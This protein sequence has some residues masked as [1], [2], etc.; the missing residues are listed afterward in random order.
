MSHLSNQLHEDAR[1]RFDDLGLRLLSRVTTFRDNPARPRPDFSPDVFNGETLTD[2]DFAIVGVRRKWK[3]TK[4]GKLTGIAFTDSTS[5]RAAKRS[6]TGE[7]SF[8]GLIGPNYEELEALARLMADARPFH[9]AASVEFLRSQIFEWVQEHHRGHV[10]SGC[11]DYVLRALESAATDHRMIFPVSQLH[12]QSPLT[13][14][15]VTVATFPES[16][17][18]K[19]EPKLIDNPSAAK[20]AEWCRSMREDFQGLAVAETCVFG[21]PIRALEIAS[22]RV[23]LAVGVL[24]FFAPSHLKPWVTSRIA[25]WGYAPSRNSYV[26]I[27]DAAGQLLSTSQ[28]MIDQPGTM[29]VDDATRDILLGIGLSEVRDIVAREADSR[30]DLE[31]ALLKGMVT[32]GRAALASDFSERI[33]WYCAGLESILLRG[34]DQIV[35]SLS[36]RLAL[37]G[38]DTVGE[39]LAAVKDVK[40]AYKLRSNFVHHGVEIGESEIVTRFAR[41]GQRVFSR[42]AQNVASFD[43]KE[44]LLSH[45]DRIKLSGSS[46]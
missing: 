40:K 28:A 35:S 25:R 2:A 16:I 19:I 18:E 3:N 34:S 24:R 26:F 12:V 1:K 5:A 38:Y 30:N 15:S 46:Q 10:S 32:F 37:F 43:S 7:D 9:L 42:I 6:S 27:V 8:V 44:E 20:R 29:V 4:T 21:E 11:V 17:F 14:G 13:L 41:H 45:I 36:E 39:R 33:V 22:D 31:Q 23:E